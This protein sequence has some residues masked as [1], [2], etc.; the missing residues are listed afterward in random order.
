MTFL[1]TAKHVIQGHVDSKSAVRLRVNP[2]DSGVGVKDFELP[3]HFDAGGWFVHPNPAIDVATISINWDFLIN[4]GIEPSFFTQ[5]Q[6]ATNRNKLKDREVA[7]GDALF[8]LGFPLGLSG[9]QRNYVIVRQGCVA[10][11]SEMLDGA[12]PTFL[13]DAQAYPG[14]SGGPVILRPEI[15]AIEGTKS[16]GTA[17]LLGLVTSYLPYTD[18]AI[19]QQTKSPRILFQE[20]SGLANVLP[21]DYIDETIAAFLAAF[22]GAHPVEPNAIPE[23]VQ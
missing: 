13:I 18:V 1:A 9:E 6:T 10:R 14:N 21:V 19:S 3:T 20:N 8:L 4:Q 16:Q 5:D 23:A 15:T 17:T 7:A 2:K 22:P 11:I 12:T